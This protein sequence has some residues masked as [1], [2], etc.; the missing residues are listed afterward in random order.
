MD[1]MILILVAVFLYAYFRSYGGKGVGIKFRLAP[2]ST[3][4]GKRER[5]A[6]WCV[7]AIALLAVIYVMVN[8]GRRSLFGV[9]V[10]FV[11]GALIFLISYFRKRD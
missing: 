11:A 6:T 8:Q 1:T 2:A 9:A 5:V 10:P 3:S 7:L 4:Q